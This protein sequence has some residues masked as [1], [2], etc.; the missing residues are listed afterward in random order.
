MFT[1]LRP[2]DSVAANLPVTRLPVRPPSPTGRAST[3]TDTFKIIS[4]GWGVQSFALADMSTLGGLTR[5]DIAVHSDIIYE[6]TLVHGYAKIRIG[7]KY[8]KQK[9]KNQYRSLVW[10]GAG[11]CR[12]LEINAGYLYRNLSGMDSCSSPRLFQEAFKQLLVQ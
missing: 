2:V 12:S 6:N 11:I 9:E 7:E 4:L 1:A 10:E 3:L 8:G 5:V